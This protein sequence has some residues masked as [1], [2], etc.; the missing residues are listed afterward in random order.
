MKLICI[1]RLKLNGAGEV[2]VKPSF[3]VSDLSF[4]IMAAQNDQSVTITG[5][6][7]HAN[8]MR[9]VDSNTTSHLFL[10]NHGVIYICIILHHE[11]FATC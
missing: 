1:L 6:T 4:L 9:L 2:V 11:L 5:L 8:G 7:Q 10:N 3:S